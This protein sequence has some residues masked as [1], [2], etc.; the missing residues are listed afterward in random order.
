MDTSIDHYHEAARLVER[1]Q[2]WMDR[3]GHYS[4]QERNGYAM[5]DLLAGLT[6]AVLALAGATALNAEHMSE[7]D[8]AVWEEAVSVTAPIPP[9][10]EDEDEE[11]GAPRRFWAIWT[12]EHDL[13]A[14]VSGPDLTTPAEAVLRAAGDE[15]WYEEWCAT[16][17]VQEVDAARFAALLDWDELPLDA[18][19]ARRPA[20]WIGE[21]SP[22][23]AAALGVWL[24]RLPIGTILSGDE[25]D[26]YQVGARIQQ[27]PGQ[28]DRQF[29][30]LLWVLGA[31]PFEISAGS[32]D[33]LG[34]AETA[35]PFTVR[36]VGAH[37]RGGTR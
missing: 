35:A 12:A 31:A 10:T 6:H 30:T 14:Q 23:D 3:D 7:E 19:P 36:A 18:R 17:V 8:F 4:L 27:R 21:C 24:R 15:D 2:Y 13:R 33:V 34:L 22:V 1:G 29:P 20:P 25:G 37:E 26:A 32:N 11:L 16:L 9:E 5:P 28:P